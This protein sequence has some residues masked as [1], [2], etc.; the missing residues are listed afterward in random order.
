MNKLTTKQVFF[1][2]IESTWMKIRATGAEFRNAGFFNAH[3]IGCANVPVGSWLRI[4]DVLQASKGL[5][6]TDRWT[7]LCGVLVHKEE[8]CIE[9][10]EMVK[11]D[12]FPGLGE[13]DV[14]FNIDPIFKQ[15]FFQLL[16]QP[17]FRECAFFHPDPVQICLVRRAK[18]VLKKE[19]RFLKNRL[20]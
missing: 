15:E 14:P 9:T 10:G 1:S 6:T 3:L 4:K 17:V 13:V 2:G 11:V 18:F 5:I 7:G 20:K 8:L 16:N 19:Q 12:P